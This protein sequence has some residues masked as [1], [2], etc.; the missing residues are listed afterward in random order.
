MHNHSNF[1]AAFVAGIG[2]LAAFAIGIEP[3][4]SQT[5]HVISVAD[6]RDPQLKVEFTLNNKAIHE[7][8]TSLSETTNMKLDLIDVTEKSYSCASIETAIKNV[9]AKPE[10]VIIFFHS[11]HG[12]SPRR[13]SK[14][15]SASI[16]PSLECASSLDAPIPNLEDLFKLLVDKK[17]RL[18]IVGAD[19]CNN[20]VTAAP[21]IKKLAPK[22]TEPALIRTMFLKYAGSILIAS[23]SPS[24]F[25]FYPD[26]SIGLFTE[27][28]IDALN[29][30]PSVSPDLIWGRVIG[31]ATVAIDVPPHQ[32]PPQEKQHPVHR[33]ELRYLS[34]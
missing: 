13:D 25:S 2:F 30:P 32:S 34:P 10:D 18:T 26:R 9:S 16:F 20:I 24:E 3:S 6:T 27:Q 23:S 12:H 11:G 8:A 31:R 22:P 29:N 7:Y 4:H 14:D 1:L 28:F 21:Q 15:E 5:L 17:A 19:S 33:E